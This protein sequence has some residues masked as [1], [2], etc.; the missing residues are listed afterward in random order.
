[1]N[2]HTNVNNDN[3]DNKIENLF[4][5]SLNYRNVRIEDLKKYKKDIVHNI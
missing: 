1:M 2:N 5:V 3:K 4:N